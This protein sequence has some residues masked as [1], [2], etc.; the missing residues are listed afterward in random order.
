V[1]SQVDKGLVG[2][3]VE[4]AAV[5]ATGWTCRQDTIAS[6]GPHKETNKASEVVG[7]DVG[8]WVR[9]WV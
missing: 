3:P 1:L 2:D 4:R 7:W 5:E 6:H 9:L 8:D